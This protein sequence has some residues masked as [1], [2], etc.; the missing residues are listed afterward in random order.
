[1]IGVLSCSKLDLRDI[2]GA[3][4]ETLAPELDLR[5]PHEIDRPEDVTFMV[6]FAPAPDAFTPYPNIR[7]VYS[8]G[9]GVDA[10]TSCPSLPSTVAVHRVEDPD[11]ARQ[12]AGFAAFHVVWH[13]RNMGDCLANQKIGHW[14]RQLTGLSPR[15]RRI[16]VLGFGHMGRT[17]AKA[18]VALGY[19][20]ASYSRSCPNPSEN[21]VTHYSSQNSAGAF[22]DFLAQSDIL[23]N[24][25]PLTDQT[26]GILGA[27]NLAKLP[28][29]A[30]LIH[31]GRGG[32][33][34]EAAL[35]DA[36][37]RGHLSGAS[38]D[39]FDT[40]PLPTDHPLWRHQKVFVTP[41]VACICEPP[42]AVLSIRR[43]Q[44][45]RQPLTA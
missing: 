5:L 16:G 44:L 30:A 14:Q 13:H 37:D 20:V 3:H 31:L 4:F 25:L 18:L 41:H 2:Y 9:A 26:R 39:V 24:V 11:Q 38:L 42:A 17:V 28:Q 15:A 36:L 10:I 22:D 45:E 43:T 27:E 21:G 40:E 1:M 7:A 32:Q 12:M 33:V 23:I 19:P 34:D 8:I 29:G 6:T 35:M